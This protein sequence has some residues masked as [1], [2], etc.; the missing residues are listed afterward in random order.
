MKYDIFLK[1]AIIAAKKA[2]VPILS[3]F[4]KIKTIKKKNKNIRDLITEVDI[5]SEKKIISSLKAKFTKHNFLAEESGLQNNKSDF[6]WIIDPLDGTVNYIKGIKLCAISIALTYKN[7]TILGVIYNP[8]SKELYYSSKKSGSYLNG[9]P[10]QVSNN[11]DLDSC[12]LVSAFSSKI[13]LKNRNKEYKNFGNL[14]NKSL[15]VLRIGSA[16][17]AMAMVAKG[18]IDGIWGSDLKIWDI[19]AG[20]CLIKEAHGQVLEKKNGTNKTIIAGNN[21]VVNKVKKILK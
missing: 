16:A 20:I 9:N 13:S 15:G 2:S 4:E 3:N 8:F 5:L 6:T 17:L 11:K 21:Y 14:N 19:E 7:E 18:S 10:I 12:L 1:Q